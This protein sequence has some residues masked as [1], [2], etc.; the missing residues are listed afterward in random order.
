ML[1]AQEFKAEIIW[2]E[3][4]FDRS[5]GLTEEHVYQVFEDRRGY[6]W[7]TTD[8]DLLFFDGSKFFKVMNHYSPET[9]THIRVRCQDS[10]GRI[11]VRYFQDGQYIFRVFNEFDRSIL[12]DTNLYPPGL[13]KEAIRDVTVNVRGDLFF[14]THD[15]DLWW[16]SPGGQNWQREEAC[17]SENLSFAFPKHEEGIWLISHP[18]QN[19][20]KRTMSYWTPDDLR[21]YD[22]ADLIHVK[23]TEDAK[24]VFLT[25]KELGT[26]D[27]NGTRVTQPIESLFPGFQPDK[28]II[29]GYNSNFGYNPNNGDVFLLHDFQ[30][31]LANL[32]SGLTYAT[33]QTPFLQSSYLGVFDN[34]NNIWFGTLEG[35][36]QIEYKLN[37]FQRIQWKDPSQSRFS[38]E[39]SARGIAVCPNGEMYFSAKGYL[40]H[41]N[42]VSGMTKRLV[43][44]NN[45]TSD[46]I[47][48]DTHKR[49]WTLGDQFIGYDPLQNSFDLYENPDAFGEG[50]TFGIYPLGDSILIS[51]S[52]GMWFFRVSDS[53]FLPFTGY[54]DFPDLRTAEVY[55]FF[56]YSPTELLLCTNKGIYR[57]EKGGKITGQYSVWGRGEFHIPALNVRHIHRDGDGV[58]WLACAEGLIRW[59]P[60]KMRTRRFTTAQGLYDSNLYGVFEDRHGFLWLS[61]NNGIMQ[62]HKATGISKHYSAED[63]ITDNEFNRISH[64]RDQDGNIYFGSLNGITRFNPDDFVFNPITL[65]PKRVDLTSLTVFDRKKGQ[66]VSK[67]MQVFS[68][69]LVLI[70]PSELNFSA[71]FAVNDFDIGVG[72]TYA[73][74]LS[75]VPN[76]QWIQLES[77]GLQ[78]P[79]LP[80]GEYDLEIRAR[81]GDLEFGESYLRVPL[82][83]IP[84]LYLRPWFILTL[85][86]VFWALLVWAVMR[87]FGRRDAQNRLLQTLVEK[88][89]A[90]IASDKL[91]IEAQAANLQLKNLEKDRFFANISHEFRTPISL[92]LGPAA[93]LSSQYTPN[94]KSGTLL[95]LIQK[96]ARQL[97]KLVNDILMLSKVEYGDIRPVWKPLRLK[98]LTQDIVRDF[99]NLFA[100]KRI[101][102]V[103]HIAQIPDKEVVQDERILR[104]VLQNLLSNA[105]KYTPA[106]GRVLLKVT[107]KENMLEIMVKDTGRGI[108]A[109]DLPRIFDRYFQS[110]DAGAQVEGGTGIGLSLVKEMVELVG[111]NISVESTWGNGTV[112]YVSLPAKPMSGVADT[113]PEPSEQPQPERLSAE[114][115][116][117]LSGRQ[118]LFV[119]DNPDFHVYLKYA[120]GEQFEFVSAANGVEA[121]RLLDT[122]WKPLLVITDL[123]MPEMDGFHLIETIKA[124]KGLQH[125]PMLILTA[126][127]EEASRMQGLKYG[128]QDYILKPFDEQQLMAA[129]V[130]LIRRSLVQAAAEAE[131]EGE[132]TKQVE[133][134]AWLADLQN[135][136]DAH[137][138][139]PD[140]SV[141]DLAALM[142]TGRT[143][144]YNQVRKLTGMT[145]N[146]LILE[147]RLQKARLML[148]ESPSP[149]VKAV[150]KAIGLKHEPHFIAAFQ[151]R[152]GYT[153]GQIKQ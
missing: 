78:I 129:L 120:L 33:N 45:G 140:F 137:I 146:Q 131:M 80:F 94:S 59:E 60:Q 82:Q 64:S 126:R 118:I 18:V 112:F 91:L 122:G 75:N 84:P 101:S 15:G 61:S 68:E 42:P 70:H 49:I 114:E 40:W 29:R 127:A 56:E 8:T 134:T 52:K 125:I 74:R 89:T 136:I 117:L 104:L 41:Y 121:M 110:E 92:I 20:V 22:V 55:S 44:T 124:K 37:P 139:N 1:H 3:R 97:L 96:N 107:T 147:T 27:T 113:D 138:H 2:A 24:L 23:K 46:V 79:G 119:E 16:R 132:N 85:A 135:N 25:K 53:T 14:L 38:H 152:F 128:I 66:E 39:F 58:F 151:K 32:K 7:I 90:T 108:R 6:F 115:V 72:V 47:W 36:R 62:Y 98:K 13:P 28:E 95:E 77:S 93:L 105:Y 150:V 5:K 48:D 21:F 67:T 86:F 43:L 133:I 73:Y 69:G 83:V 103:A 81:D 54:G 51:N 35:L 63:G 142:L 57:W 109:A 17:I 123:M 153:P 100:T 4:L 10:E 99:S 149:T 111:G 9:Y 88:S 143:A 31:E 26:L 12:S 30:L 71:S 34:D 106:Q 76:S 148:Q 87:E 116:R 145:P 144:F 141:N 50:Y 19:E 102:F 11:W 130:H 65:K